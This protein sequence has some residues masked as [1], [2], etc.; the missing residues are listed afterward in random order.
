MTP[1]TT[2]VQRLSSAK[3]QLGEK[4]VEPALTLGYPSAV[5]PPADHLRL[6][7]WQLKQAF[8]DAYLCPCGPIKRSA[9]TGRRVVLA[10]AV[11]PIVLQVK[12]L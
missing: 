6:P 2:P 11:T 10:E 8:P 12:W 7:A 3:F 5:H 4:G 9:R 1:P